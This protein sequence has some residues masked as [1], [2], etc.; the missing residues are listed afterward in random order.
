MTSRILAEN[1]DFTLI[2]LIR[3]SAEK[4]HQPAEILKKSG[5]Q[6]YCFAHHKT[7][8]GPGGY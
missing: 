2:W 5:W 1:L 8:L 6:V 3:V 4:A 7:T